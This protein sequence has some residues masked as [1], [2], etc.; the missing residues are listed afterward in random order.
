VGALKIL[1]REGWFGVEELNSRI[2]NYKLYAYEQAD[3]PTP[4][5]PEL[6]Q[7]SIHGKA[8]STMVLLREVL[9]RRIK[10]H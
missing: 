1:R 7:K 8:M 9:S 5:K 2:K 4:F 3:Q 6:K 10:S